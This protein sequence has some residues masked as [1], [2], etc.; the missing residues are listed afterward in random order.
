[1]MIQVSEFHPICII[2]ERAK[3]TFDETRDVGKGRTSFSDHTL[4]RS[5]GQSCT[6]IS[7]FPV[8][9]NSDFFSS[10]VFIASSD[11]TLSDAT[12]IAGPNVFEV[13]LPNRTWPSEG[14]VDGY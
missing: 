11:A 8:V 6:S 13:L 9:L 10:D 4:L 7:T 14:V 5:D 3:K 12:T 2:D 1:M